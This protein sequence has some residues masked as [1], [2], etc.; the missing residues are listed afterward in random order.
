MFE[1][2]PLAQHNQQNT[3]SDSLSEV[4]PQSPTKQNNTK[5]AYALYMLYTRPGHREVMTL[6]PPGSTFDFAWHSFQKTFKRKTGIE[7]ND[8]LRDIAQRDTHEDINIG[9]EDGAR[10]GSV[11][12]DRGLFD[13]IGMRRLAERKEQGLRGSEEG[14]DRAGKKPTVTV[15]LNGEESM[16]KS[17]ID[18]RA[19]T[20]IDGW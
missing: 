11:N 3:S 5:K 10:D 17:L 15:V 18:G 2:D 8:S 20:P 1:F 4:T 9:G 12:I 7:W 19:R 14:E 16:V 6:A 13:F